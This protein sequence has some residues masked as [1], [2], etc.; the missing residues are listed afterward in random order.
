MSKILFVSAHAPTNLY[1]QAG[2]KIALKNLEDYA[3]S[4]ATVDIVVIAN[5]IEITAATDLAQKFGRHLYAFPL[6]K[7]KK[8]SG[9]LINFSIPFK[10]ST[11]LQSATIKK[12]KSLLETNI[13]D[14]VHF[15][16]SHAGVYVDLIQHYV[17]PNLTKTIVSIHDVV[18]QSFL[19]KT[20]SNL[21]L[22]I[23][24]ARLFNYEK[25]LYSAVD[26]LWVLSKKDCN[27]LTSLFGI[28]EAK[29][30]VKPPQV[31]SFISQ[32]KR[33]P[34]KVEKKSLLFWGAMNRSENEQAVLTFIEKCF[35][36]V[37]ETDPSFRLYIVGSNP[38]KQLLALASNNIIVTGFVEDPIHLFE[39]AQIGIVPLLQGAGVKLKT[40]EML[41]AGLPVI[42]TKIGAEGVDYVG[43]QLLVN[44]NFDQWVDWILKWRVG[45]T[46]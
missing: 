2:Q 14:L 4:G 35:N 16:Y 33:H 32:V 21:I 6:S 19:R 31:S 37:L 36:K 29:I 22:G 40:L 46:E 34:E 28:P 26:E 30:L 17:N 9:C 41:E 23:E 11:R 1:P 18:S 5:Q 8:I 3:N 24:V 7:W 43:E 10:F 38:S 44:D 12:L 13:Y 39:K 20:E 42:A 15:E 25:T 45:N 27:I